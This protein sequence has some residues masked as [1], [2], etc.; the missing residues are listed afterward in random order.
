[1][2]PLNLENYSHSARFLVAWFY[3]TSCNF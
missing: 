1:L 3:S 2:L